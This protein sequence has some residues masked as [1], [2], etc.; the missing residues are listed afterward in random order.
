MTILCYHSVDPHW[1][2]PMAV[3]PSEF[4]RHCTWLSR[5]RRVLP[6]D[7]AVR[8]LDRTGRLPRGTAALTLDDGF[9]ELADHA[10]PVLRRLALPATVFLV[11]QT[12]TDAGQQVD[13]VDTPRTVPLTTLTRDQVLA[14]QDLGVDFQSHS[15]AHVDLTRLGFDACVDD[16]RSSRE[17]LSDVLSRPV[18]MLAYPRGRHDAVVRAAAERAGYTSAFALP[19]RGEPPGPFAVPRVGVHR[20]NGAWTVRLKSTRSYLPVRNAPATARAR[21]LAGHVLEGAR[22]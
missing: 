22:A 9:A 3:T 4:E 7:E 15:W 20:G 6:L 8:R 17:L 18:S 14:M 19:E 1:P 16:L 11:A 13:W 2:S 12:L 5:H 21:R 10:T